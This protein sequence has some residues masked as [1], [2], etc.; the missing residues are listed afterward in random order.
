MP[1]VVCPACHSKLKAPAALV[2]KE[3]ACPR[4]KTQIH[5]TSG[6]VRAGL[7]EE[8]KTH[9]KLAPAPNAETLEDIAL[10][11]TAEQTPLRLPTAEPLAESRTAAPKRGG[12]LVRTLLF[13]ALA[14]AGSFAVWMAVG[15]SLLDVRTSHG[16]QTRR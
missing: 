6:L 4:C 1:A 7:V 2:G 13:V 11:D 12:W 3:A 9:K 8:S 5:V 16:I 15:G 10:D 14:A